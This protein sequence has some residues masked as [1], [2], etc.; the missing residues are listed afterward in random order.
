MK[1]TEK[2]K[3]LIGNIFFLKV[4]TSFGNGEYFMY[5]LV[6]V[7]G[8]KSQASFGVKALVVPVQGDTSE[9]NSVSVKKLL[10]KVG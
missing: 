7:I 2:Y 4:Y 9:P 10:T 6:R 5:P 3:K 8:I 1:K